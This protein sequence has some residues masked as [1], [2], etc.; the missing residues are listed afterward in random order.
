MEYQF[1]ANAV[2]DDGKSFD[3][4]PLPKGDY[5]VMATESDLKETLA[6]TGKYI[7]FTLV[8]IEGPHK[9]RI[10][11]LKIN[12]ENPNQQAVDIG[13]REYKRMHEAIGLSSSTR[14]EDLHNKPF[15]VRVGFGK[16]EYS[17]KNEIKGFKPYGGA[18]TVVAPAASAPA[19]A[20]PEAAAA[21]ATTPA[22]AA[23][24]DSLPPW[25]R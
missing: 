4:S 17:E 5:P 18:K 22:P 12:T 16:G 13:A 24:S 8:V 20:A 19:A 11:W 25:K 2:P 1:N 15:V 9:D 3:D 6:K 14:T 7:E 21:P 23:G 10:M